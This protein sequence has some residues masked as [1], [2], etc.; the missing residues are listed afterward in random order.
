MILEQIPLTHIL[1]FMLYGGITL[2]S[3]I[4]CIYLLFRDGNAFAADV[5]PSV[6]LRRW[7]VVFFALSFLSHVWWFLFYAISHDISPAKYV[8]VVVLDT[9]TLFPAVA[10]TLIYMLQD[11]KRPIWPIFVAMIPSVLLG[12]IQMLNPDH[13]YLLIEAVYILSFY[14][15]L[16]VYMLFAVK[17]YGRWLR[18]NYADLEHK[19]VWKTQ[20]AV[21][22]SLLVFIFYW[23]DNNITIAYLL[24]ITIF[25]LIAV[26]L[27]RVETL[28]QLDASIHTPLPTVAGKL[29][30]ADFFSQI[31]R[32]LAERC[33][34]SQL[35]LQHDLTLA[36]LAQAVGTNRFYLSQYF[37]SQGNT[38]NAYINDLR[39]DHFIGLYREAANARRPFTL[40]QLASDSGYHSYSTF[41]LAFRQRK[42]QSVK[43]WMRGMSMQ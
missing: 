3:V 12:T 33:E 40:Q 4:A 14:V 16:V 23:I 6:R 1:Y 22:V 39:I 2:V 28:P 24:Q 30:G 34:A 7:V 32:L 37:S 9:V 15:L 25:W 38:Y 31:E 36:Q 8:A 35:Y 42:G 43:A 19:E 11:H 18:D 5:T 27:W 41:S 29:A 21:M 17:Q 20:V 10:G 26:L 13:D